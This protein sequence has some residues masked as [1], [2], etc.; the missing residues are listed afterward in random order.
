MKQK[1]ATVKPPN[2][3]H[4]TLTIS[5]ANNTNIFFWPGWHMMLH[6]YLSC[7]FQK[8][9]LDRGTVRS[10]SLILANALKQLAIS[11]SHSESLFCIF[12]SLTKAKPLMQRINGLKMNETTPICHVHL[13]IVP[14]TK[15]T[16]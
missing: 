15:R 13:A 7:A 4:H 5:F 8:F 12:H 9:S 2:V 14:C 6:A 3:C 1:M 16:A 10:R 11:L